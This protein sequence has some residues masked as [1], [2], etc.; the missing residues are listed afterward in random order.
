MSELSD[1]QDELVELRRRIAEL[2]RSLKE[3]L[4][5]TSS[6]VEAFDGLVYICSK[7][8][9]VEF[10]NKRLIERTGYNPVGQRCYKALHDLDKI[11]P[12]CVNDRVFKGETVRWEVQSPKDNNWYY[13]V[14]TPV[15]HTDGSISKMAMIQDITERKRTEEELLKLRLGIE[16]SNE[17][18][19][20]TDINGTIV[21][22]NPAFEKIY[23]YS[24]EEALGKTPRILKSGVLPQEVYKQ[25]WDTLIA[26]KIVTGELINKTKDERLLNIEGSAN[27][28]LDKDGNIAGFLAIQ[29]DIT[30]RKLSEAALRESEERYRNL[31]ELSPDAIAI[32]S[33][34][35]FVF[36][37]TA[38]ARLLGA[39]TSEQ[40]IGKKVIDIVHPDSRELVEE[41]IRQQRE[42]GKT[43]P[44]IEEKLIRL[45]GSLIDVEVA[46]MPFTYLGRPG[47]QVI[48]RDITGRKRLEEK[49][50]KAHD[51]LEIRVQER[52]AELEE[53]NKALQA[54]ITERR[55]VEKK[56]KL[57]S[58]AVENAPDCVQIVDLDGYIIYSSRAA[59]DIY[60]FSREELIGR[61][62]NEMNADPEFAGRVILPIIKETGRWVGELM[63]KHKNGRLFPIWL[64][65]S[66][67]KD[68]KGEPIAMVGINRDITEHRKMEEMRLEND[69]LV[70]IDKVKSEILTIMSH[71]LRTPL[72][73]VIGYSIILKEKKPGKLNKKQEFLVENILTSSKHL[74]DIINNVLDLA[75]I[76]VGKLE[77]KIE[78]IP[79][80]DTINEIIN[81]MQEK[82][83]NHN[84]ILKKEFDPELPYIKADMQKF[85]QI[86]FNLLGNAIKFSKPAGG[87]VT[88]TTKKA[89]NT[90][91]FSVSDTG[92]GIREEDMSRL[93]HVF[94]QLDKGLSRKYEGTG[95]GLAITKQLVE[96]QGGKIIVESKY[97]EGST[98]TFL[99]PL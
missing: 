8:Y 86:L 77:I 79:V 47:M 6:M 13:I 98:F 90:A 24:K 17:A 65:A 25:F 73:S 7:N 89:G 85:K 82:A 40:I 42:E 10:A 50:R 22:V 78:D 87:T 28:I 70:Y 14:N 72:T 52:T 12:W 75:K 69:R 66:I 51:E 33:E 67:V 71:E 46:A 74:L 94:E 92:I 53:A 54:E 64:N 97:G 19:F 23:G 21:Y 83:E 45:D 9:E 57:L 49:L 68:S 58:V 62:V 36:L 16:R 29:R 80:P 31:V 63:V 59:E 27:P 93:F 56:L 2:E 39:A 99:L 96:M 55:N 5:R 81:L 41:R 95:L 20:I 91:K 1:K 34:G 4:S 3:S 48:A 43:V 15:Y 76:E 61:H 26:K 88:V 84:V 32:H 11:C 37:N 44:L 30:E 38:G 60:G 35:K 18:I